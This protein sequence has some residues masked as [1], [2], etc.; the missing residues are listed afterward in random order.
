MADGDGF[1]ALDA[2]RDEGRLGAI[3]LGVRDLNFHREAID[4]GRVD[5][6]LPYADYNLVRRTAVPLM[7]H[8]RANGVGVILGSPQM[9]GLLA[10]GDPMIALK[11]RAYRDWYSSEDLSLIHI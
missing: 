2:L 7:K 8:A 9:Q 4:A 3:G 1:D 6:I 11:I 5:A 10:H